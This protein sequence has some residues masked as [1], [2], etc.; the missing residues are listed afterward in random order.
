M[1]GSVY[2][3]QSLRTIA[4]VLIGVFLFACSAEEQA[5]D[6]V[7]RAIWPDEDLV[8][9]AV[10]ADDRA[11]VV[12]LS[13]EIYRTM[14]A[15]STW[16][17]AH[18]PVVSSLRAL[19]MVDD[20]RGWAVGDGVILRTDDGGLRWRRQRLPGPSASMPLIR[21]SAMDAAQALAVGR[22]GLVLRTEDGGGSWVEVARSG[23]DGM[24]S[25]MLR[26]DIFCR[27]EFGGQCWSA[28][29]GL[30]RVGGNGEGWE[31][32]V[33]DDYSTLPPIH[34]DLE[35]VELNDA[36]E[37]RLEE[38]VVENRQRPNLDWVLEPGIGLRELETI[39]QRRDPSALF[40]LLAARLQEVQTVIEEGG[41]SPGRLIVLGEPPWDYEDY[42]D[43]DTR[44]LDRYWAER[45]ALGAGLRLTL[46]DQLLLESLWIGESGLGL[47]VGR[48]GAIVRSDDGGG[49]WETL[50]PS[51][52]Y[53][54]LGVG[55]G[56]ERAVAVGAQGGVWTSSDEGRRW[57]PAEID[58]RTD[59]FDTLRGISFSPSGE[60]GLVVGEHGRMLRSLDGGAAWAELR[61]R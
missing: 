27:D 3:T 57:E 54:L 49:H 51:T 12:G 43:E 41:V 10:T 46:R 13:G 33:L 7:S 6:P 22:E 48:S 17:L 16:Q 29:R 25:V 5:V 44:F 23:G 9:V 28:G 2:S 32:E 31:P 19:V 34:F 14:D 61:S 40:D 11:L 50:P 60:V 15:G 18:V 52:P 30:E 56:S 4:R 55:I 36:A 8:A 47:A 26:N 37:A 58:A 59:S 38:F 21:V 42:L 35:Q 39:G 45:L 1:N 24:K 53:D 20:E